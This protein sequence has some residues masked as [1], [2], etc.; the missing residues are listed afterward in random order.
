ME[1]LVRE[2]IST[3][4]ISNVGSTAIDACLRIAGIAYAGNDD[5]A[6][7]CDGQDFLVATIHESYWPLIMSVTL[8]TLYDTTGVMPFD[9]ACRISVS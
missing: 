7:D 4:R 9:T 3:D 6:I 1:H 8:G 2:G 5:L